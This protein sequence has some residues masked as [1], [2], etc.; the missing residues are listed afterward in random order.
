MINLI[1]CVLVSL[2]FWVY[3]PGCWTITAV[4]LYTSFRIP[5]TKKY[6]IA[7]LEAFAAW[8]L[9]SIWDG[10][11]RTDPAVVAVLIEYF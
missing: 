7:E 11:L 5:M 4:V 8:A 10:R 3:K 1:Y 6:E 2:L 9:N